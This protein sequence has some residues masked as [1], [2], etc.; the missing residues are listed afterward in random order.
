[1]S[2][3]SIGWFI[4]MFTIAILTGCSE[5]NEDVNKQ[6]SEVSLDEK[7]KSEITC[8]H[9]GHKKM[10]TL[11]TE[12]CLIRYTC[13]NCNQELTPLGDDCFVFCTYGTHKCPSMQ[14]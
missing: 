13:E 5:S 1:M 8:P 14:K 6:T 4:I 9:C 11:P 10:E 7:E 3:L 2:K 12:V